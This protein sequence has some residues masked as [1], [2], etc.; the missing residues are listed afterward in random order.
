MARFVLKLYRPLHIVS[1][2]LTVLISYHKYTVDCWAQD[3]TE[4]VTEAITTSEIRTANTGL[5]TQFLDVDGREYLSW[6]L[7]SSALSLCIK[8][9]RP[10]LQNTRSS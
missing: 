3:G 2:S 7:C 6:C 10:R 1:F 4:G 9:F 8:P 5:R